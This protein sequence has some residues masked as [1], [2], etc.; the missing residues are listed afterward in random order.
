MSLNSMVSNIAAEAG[1]ALSIGGDAIISSDTT[2]KQLVAI[3][4]RVVR[5]AFDSFPWWQFNK[6]YSFPL[7]DGVA[8]YPLPGDFSSYHYDTW[9]NKSNRW[10]VLGAMTAQEFGELEGFG[11]LQL[12]TGRFMLRGVTD[13]QIVISPTPGAQDDT[14]LIIFQY[15]SNRPVKPW[16]WEANSGLGTKAWTFYN[17]NY[18]RLAS[19]STTGTTP[20]VHTSGTVFDGGCLWTFYSG[21][22]DTFRHGEDSSVLSERIIEQGILE[23]YA[24][25]KNMTIEKSYQVQLE[26]EYGKDAPGR[27]LYTATTLPPKIWAIGGKATFR[28]N[29][30]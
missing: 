24:T 27:T 19:G 28:G 1:Y 23:R 6:S 8:T 30:F 15:I 29:S 21:A 26:E 17:G 16:T 18:Y 3:A 11:N 14:K 5:E 25:Y 7:V 2:A 20:P 13:N 10:R 9:W 4:Q 22:Y 12:T